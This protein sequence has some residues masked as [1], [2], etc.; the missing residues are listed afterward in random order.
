[1]IK[2]YNQV[3]ICEPY[4]GSKGLRTKISSGLASVEQKTGVI[5][6]K[7]LKD[8]IIDENLKIAA[9]SVVF[10]KEEILS[11][12]PF[13]TT[14]HSCKGFKGEFVLA[15]FAHVQFIEG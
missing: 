4:S 5:G 14:K 8:A 13:Y 3:I 1:M 10:I 6:L 12:H 11:T 2:S 9:G 7:V 15:N